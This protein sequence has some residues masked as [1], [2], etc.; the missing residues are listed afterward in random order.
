MKDKDNQTAIVL[1]GITLSDRD[2]HCVQ[3]AP[4]DSYV[5]SMQTNVLAI[6]QPNI[7]QGITLEEL[8]GER[9]VCS[10]TLEPVKDEAIEKLEAL[11]EEVKKMHEQTEH[12]EQRLS[13]VESRVDI[14]VRGFE[15][16]EANR[17]KERA[18]RVEQVRSGEDAH[19][20]NGKLEIFLDG[21]VL[22][23]GMRADALYS[24]AMTL[25]A[26]LRKK[27]RLTT[28]D[29]IASANYGERASRVKKSS[30]GK[31]IT[32]V[33]RARKF[34]EDNSFEFGII[35]RQGQGWIFEEK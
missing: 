28:Y 29:D 22:I 27:H 20:F 7:L 3:I 8:S 18:L 21:T 16:E 17:R 23:R 19:A 35:S 15:A 1:T 33:S 4:P 24:T 6:E 12:G 34:L 31:F 14:L 32:Y 2:P 13:S 11:A 9:D 30:R 25:Y 5:A 26:L 10:I